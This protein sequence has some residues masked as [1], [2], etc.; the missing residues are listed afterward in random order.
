[1]TVSRILQYTIAFKGFLEQ[2]FP[3]ASDAEI[4]NR[5]PPS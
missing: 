3:Q 1:M 4:T 5:G 2:H